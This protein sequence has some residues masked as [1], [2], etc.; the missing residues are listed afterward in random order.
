MKKRIGVLVNSEN[1]FA[2]TNKLEEEKFIY[3]GFKEKI[4][5]LERLKGNYIHIKLSEYYREMAENSFLIR[6]AFFVAYAEAYKCKNVILTDKVNDIRKITYNVAKYIQSIK[7]LVKQGTM[8]NM[9]LSFINISEDIA[10]KDEDVPTNRFDYGKCEILYS[11]GIDCTVA[12]YLMAKMNKK[13]LL[14]NFR[15]GQKNA[16]EEKYCCNYFKENTAKLNCELLVEDLEGYYKD[17][18]FSSGLLRDDLVLCEDNE[19]LEYVPFRNTFFFAIC[20]WLA[21]YNNIGLIVSGSQGDDAVSPDNSP[22]YYESLQKVVELQKETYGIKIYPVLL[23]IGGKPEVIKVGIELGVDFK[24]CWTCHSN[25]KW[26]S[27]IPFQCG[28]CS[29]CSTRYSAF[30]KN[31]L[32][33]PLP[34][35]NKPRIRKKWVGPSKNLNCILRQIENE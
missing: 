29:D 24:Y 16:Y 2:L 32:V 8:N 25:A 30:E 31:G 21:Q 19:V 5:I 4:G 12:A 3:F 18:M 10:D 33:D 6:I 22:L 1:D 28:V 13:L 27:E 17:I 14:V 35:C 7:N 20:I 34:Y 15:Y 11:G 9:D 26:I 23:D